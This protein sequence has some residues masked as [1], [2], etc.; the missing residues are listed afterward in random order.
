MHLNRVFY[1]IISV[2]KSLGCDQPICNPMNCGT[3]GSSVHG[4]LQ[5]RI[6]EWA[7]ISFSRGSSW[8]RDRTQVSCTADSFFPREVHK[9]RSRLAYAL[10]LSWLGTQCSPGF[11]TTAGRRGWEATSS[12]SLWISCDVN[13]TPSFWRHLNKLQKFIWKQILSSLLVPCLL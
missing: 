10:L 13:Y 2:V 12:G 8:P 7:A 6:L 1:K 4:I 5:A 3:P 9:G 11:C